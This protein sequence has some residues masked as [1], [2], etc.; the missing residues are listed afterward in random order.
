MSDSGSVAALNYRSL[1]LWHETAGEDWT[2]RPAL[3]GPATADVAIV[4][5]GFTGLWTAYHLLRSDPT[6]RVLVLEREVAGFG[7]SGRNGGWCSALFPASAA[8]LAAM[9]RRAGVRTG[10]LHASDGARRMHRAMVGAV[11]GVLQ[12]CDRE[13]IDASQAHGGTVVV[14]RSPVQLRRARA[15][16]EDAR[17][18]G[19]GEA[20]IRLL[21]QAEAREML[22]ASDVLGGTYTP[23]CA[24][25]HPAR[26]VRGLARAVERLGGVIHERTPVLAIE[27][28]GARTSAGDVRADVV[29]RATEG[30]TS[31]LAGEQRTLAPVYSLMVATEP[32]TDATW[33]ELGLTRRQTFSD[34]RHLIIY[35]QRTADGRIAFGGR[36]APYHF[37][38]R[39][40]REYDRE[41]TV[42]AE[43]KQTLVDLLP[44]LRHVEFTHAWGG[45]LGIPRDWCASVGLDRA[46][47]LGWAGG[48]VG[49]G[50]GTSYLA[51]ATLA[52]LVTGAESELVDL[53]W[54]G[55]RSRRWEPEPL[56]WVGVNVGLRTMTAA[57][58][59][60][61]R[62]GRA[63]VLARAMAPLLGGH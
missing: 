13:R 34:G 29:V 28:G 56:R 32:L 7:A 40:R 57:D 23:H 3:P 17:A 14:A 6:L 43:L 58:L 61:R 47:G 62:T 49:D 44:Q 22:A 21:D 50:V 63:S 53:P 45:P 20:D 55:H 1:S 16:V 11:H 19:R 54:V 51:G 42:F 41:P 2:P 31:S 27:P 48:Y 24:V 9:P 59:E 36:G 30:F 18:W 15:E 26:L 39:V 25:V 46:T 37:G 12:A 5:A 4:G 52:D 35:G 60:E 38:S 33:A 10:E 8:T